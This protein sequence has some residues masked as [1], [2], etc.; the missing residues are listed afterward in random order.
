M[1]SLWTSCGAL[2][3]PSAFA[4]TRRSPENVRCRLFV[5]FPGGQSERVA[6]LRR[7]LFAVRGNQPDQRLVAVACCRKGGVR[8]LYWSSLCFLGMAINNL[9]L[10]VDLIVGPNW[11]LSMAPNIA[12]LVSLALLCYGLIWDAS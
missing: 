12:N 4:K 6:V 2:R 7:S 8:L 1:P 5:V 11:D 10:Y 3:M 9:L